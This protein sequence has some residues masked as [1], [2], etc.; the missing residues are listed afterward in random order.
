MLLYG[1]VTSADTTGMLVSDSLLLAENPLWRLVLEAYLTKTTEAA[2]E[3]AAERQRA[4]AAAKQNAE[5][6]E[7]ESEFNGEGSDSGHDLTTATEDRWLSRI[8]EVEGVEPEELSSVH[9]RLI[10]HGFLK[11]KLVGRD[12]L[13]YQLTP[14]GRRVAQQA[15][16]DGDAEGDECLDEVADESLGEAA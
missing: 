15:D 1:V 2:E 12:G 11:F 13:V 10:A 6:T 8:D 5:H 9:G 16:E 14:L 4:K 3:R 7:D